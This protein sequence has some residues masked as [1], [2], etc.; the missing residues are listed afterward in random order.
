MK[1]LFK[2]RKTNRAQIQQYKL[3]LEIPK[4]NQ[5]SFS[6]KRLRT[7][8]PRVWN[9]LTFHIKSKDNLQAF[10]DVIIFI[11]ILIFRPLFIY[12]LGLLFVCINLFCIWRKFEPAIL[13]TNSSLLNN[14]KLYFR[15]FVGN[16]KK[17]CVL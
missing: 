11:L 3:N 5:V 7:Q 1:N 16:N 4:F 6:T 17:I 15:T 2:A 12:H 9:A 13:S 8:G 14:G 10:K